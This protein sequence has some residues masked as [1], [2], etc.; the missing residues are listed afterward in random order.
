LKILN[1]PQRIKQLTVEKT[2]TLANKF[3]DDKNVVKL[4]LLPEKK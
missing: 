2:K 4:V 1:A 3:F